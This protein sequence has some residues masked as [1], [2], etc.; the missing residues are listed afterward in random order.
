MADHDDHHKEPT[1]KIARPPTADSAEVL[2]RR[3]RQLESN[4]KDW[5]E[6]V[7]KDLRRQKMELETLR[8]DNDQFKQGLNELRVAE[9]TSSSAGGGSLRN[10]NSLRTRKSKELDTK[11]DMLLHLENK[12]HN[13]Q[14]SIAAL[15]EELRQTQ[16]R[17]RKARSQMGGVNVTKEGHEMIH[18]QVSVLENRLDQ[19]LVRFNEVL[20]QNKELR[21]QI[22]T[23]R[24]E[25]DVFESIYQKL[26]AELQEK[27]KEMAF[28]IEV[29]NIAYEERD[30]NVQVLNNLKTFAS[31]EMNSFAET[32]K[33]LDDLL[34]ED[35]RMK[36]QVKTRISTL[37][38]KLAA[39]KNDRSSDD[40][41]RKGGNSHAASLNPQ[42]AATPKESTS[43]SHAYEEAFNRIR[44]A[45]DIPD[46]GEL[47]QRFL[48]AEEENY[49]LFSF[50]NDLQKDIENLEK[51]R[52][53][54]L[55]EI[56]HISLGNTEDQKRRG[57]LKTLEEKLRGEEH[58]NQT[59]IDLSQKIDGN[60]RGVMATVESIFTRLDCDDTLIVE[61]HGVSG[62]TLDNLLLYLA[63]IELRTDEY[64]ASWARQTG[65]ISEISGGRGPQ[66]PFDSM[67]VTVDSKRLPGTGED[68]G[69]G[70]DDD[71]HPLSREE[72]LRKVHKKM[73]AQA[74]AAA[75]RRTVRGGKSRVAIGGPMK[76]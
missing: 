22:D 2:R 34:E 66:A 11:R 36:E 33:E 39:S 9:A 52:T 47:V 3:L 45:T 63:S 46:L 18:R 28:I 26:E 6:Q 75:E 29:S 57:Q 25:R 48:R 14:Q 42:D 71:D 61:Q 8:R 60:L 12:V 35:R 16:Q 19:S 40:K 37:E 38:R 30:N 59:C 15:G 43:A 69:E 5:Q 50:V 10:P 41:R 4:H 56:E 27:K 64:V 58:K 20:R 76:K 53:E 7:Q 70:S 49:S 67:Q 17:V 62:L 32:F 31:E 74:I 51:N 44:Q 13:E 1:K 68:A 23:L 73:N 55:D 21:E 54:L 24:G 65:S 72:L